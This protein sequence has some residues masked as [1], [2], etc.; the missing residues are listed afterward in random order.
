MSRDIVHVSGCG[1]ASDAATVA[2]WH[3]DG[4]KDGKVPDT[5]GNARHLTPVDAGPGGTDDGFVG[6]SPFIS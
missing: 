1:F 5:S 4:L 6:Q 2:L 3:L